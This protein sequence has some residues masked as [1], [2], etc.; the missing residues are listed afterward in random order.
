[1]P[2]WEHVKSWNYGS[3]WMLNLAKVASLPRLLAI[4]HR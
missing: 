2:E 1:M 4:G 3:K